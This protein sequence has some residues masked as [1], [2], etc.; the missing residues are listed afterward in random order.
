MHPQTLL[1]VFVVRVHF[2]IMVSLRTSR[3]FSINLYSSWLLISLY[4]CLV[5]FLPR[6]RTLYFPL[7]N[8]VRLLLYHFSSLVRSLR[9]AASGI[10]AACLNFCITYEIAVKFFII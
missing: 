7:L 8:G 3:A 2:W 10:S 5:F 9:V 4:Q 6:C 1:A